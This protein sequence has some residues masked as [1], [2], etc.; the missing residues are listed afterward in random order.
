M[1]IE[2]ICLTNEQ[3]QRLKAIQLELL[4]EF[5]RV[6]KELHLTYFLCAG[7]LLGAVRHGGFIPWD[8][9][10]D[11]QMPRS[12]YLL[13]IREAKKYLGNKY[14]VSSFYTEPEFLG[15]FAK[16]VD[17]STTYIEVSTYYRN[18]AKGCN[19]D[20]FPIDYIADNALKRFFYKTKIDLFR[21]RINK[22]YYLNDAY[23]KKSFK[24]KVF[25]L[26]ASFVTFFMKPEKA[27]KRMLAY[28][29]KHSPK[30]KTNY[31]VVESKCKRLYPT[32]IFN[33]TRI[34]QFEGKQYDAPIDLNGYLKIQYGPDYMKLPP[35]EKRV[36]HHYCAKID[37]TNGYQHD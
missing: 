6:C 1:K 13:F 36:A 28:I 10:I 7:T 31:C 30:N 15:D 24:G 12:D 9:D 3:I 5:V 2:T 17:V 35:V 33:D 22:G 23:S 29:E 37:F 21:Q 27:E 14:V 20:I 11:V 34:V 8:D 4:N 18:I 19:I 32:S 26:F 16:L 25:G